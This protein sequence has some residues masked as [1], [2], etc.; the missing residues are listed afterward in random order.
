M[1][2]DCSRR[3]SRDTCDLVDALVLH[4]EERDAGSF[5]FFQCR[6]R[7]VNVHLLSHVVL[8]GIPVGIYFPAIEVG[9]FLSAAKVIIKYNYMQYGKAR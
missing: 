3:T 1:A 9:C 4:V 2:F 7:P 8:G 5:H 6:Q